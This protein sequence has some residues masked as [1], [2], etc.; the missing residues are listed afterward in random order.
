[1]CCF[2]VS[3]GV[4]LNFIFMFTIFKATTMRV[5]LQHWECPLQLTQKEHHIYLNLILSV[6]FFFLRPGL[7]LKSVST[8]SYMWACFL[9]PCLLSLCSCKSYRKAEAW[10]KTVEIRTKETQISLLQTETTLC[11]TWLHPYRSNPPFPLFH[12]SVLSWRAVKI[13]RSCRR[14]Q[15]LRAFKSI[16]CAD[17]VT[18]YEA[19]LAPSLW[20]AEAD[21]RC[22]NCR[23]QIEN[24]DKKQWTY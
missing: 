13:V 7:N 12:C 20:L 3:Q 16:S 24:G 9:W 2:W 17:E 23:V 6:A 8:R 10:S 11:A 19:Q 4:L 14:K 22:T 1:M 21:I 18:G 5:P 15:H